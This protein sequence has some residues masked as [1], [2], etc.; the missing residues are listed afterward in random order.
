[1]SSEPGGGAGAYVRK[2]KVVHGILIAHIFG[3]VAGLLSGAMAM[4]FRK[5]SSWHATAG[6][7]FF[8]SMLLMSGAGAFMATVKSDPGNFLGG[9]LTFYLVATAWVTARRREARTGI[10]DWVGLAAIAAIAT[11]QVTFGLQAA[12]SATG[13]RFGYPPGPYL[14]MGTVA[15]LATAGDVRMLVRGGV[16]G[17]QRIARHLWRMCFALFIASASVFL[18][19]QHLFPEFMRK[20][21]MLVLLSFL[22]L[23]LMIFWL[24]RV[25]FR[26]LYSSRSVQRT[27]MAV[28]A[29][30]LS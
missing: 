29:S 16:S 14:M 6:N 2:E 19:R 12:T 8:V 26:N 30:H 27:A 11:F 25:R 1:M 18:A 23:L 17:T 5:G 3:A 24:L 15:L 13:V 7:V 10:F 21:G 9:A 22:P 4:A 20:T 28:P